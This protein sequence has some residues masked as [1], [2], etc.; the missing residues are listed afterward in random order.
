MQSVVP[1]T[2]L[3]TQRNKGTSWRD[4]LELR[5]SVS[6]CEFPNPRIASRVSSI[7]ANICLSRFGLPVNRRAPNPRRSCA[8]WYAVWRSTHFVQRS[9]TGGLSPTGDRHAAVS[10]FSKT[11]KKS[12]DPQLDA[13]PGLLLWFRVVSR[14]LPRCST[15]TSRLNRPCRSSPSLHSSPRTSW[16]PFTKVRR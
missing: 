2:F 9:G 1:Q 5:I 15:A 6:D 3:K 13:P 16:R 7:R 10:C 12:S 11:K 14:S 8:C 4:P